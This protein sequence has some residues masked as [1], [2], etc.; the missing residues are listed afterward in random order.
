VF[1]LQSRIDELQGA[2]GP[3][4]SPHIPGFEQRS[5]FSPR[6]SPFSGS[7]A[8]NTVTHNPLLNL[9]T[10]PGSQSSPSTDNSFIGSQVTS[11]LG[12]EYHRLITLAGAAVH[13]D[14]NA[15]SRKR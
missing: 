12:S 8:G 15:V 13:D 5:V 4:G 3:S 9:T 7:S 2:A 11:S 1:R 6:S 10:I 14:S